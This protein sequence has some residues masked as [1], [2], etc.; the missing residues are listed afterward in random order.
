MVRRASPLNVVYRF[1]RA[2]G[3]KRPRVPRRVHPITRRLFELMQLHFDATGEGVREIADKSG[4]AAGTIFHWATE[5]RCHNPS[6]CNLQ[7]VLN[8]LGHELYVR[9]KKIVEGSQTEQ[10][11]PD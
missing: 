5:A 6:L 8:Y 1:H 2:H 3:N 9:E 10:K 11:F 7:A 4:V